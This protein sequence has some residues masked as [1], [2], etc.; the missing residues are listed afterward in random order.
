MVKDLKEFLEEIADALED[1]NTEVKIIIGDEEGLLKKELE[2]GRMA[3]VLRLMESLSDNFVDSFSDIMSA[4]NRAVNAADVV[5]LKTEMTEDINKLFNQI[6]VD[7][8]IQLKI[9]EK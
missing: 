4:V 3:T 8:K 1:E 5:G 2:Q 6:S 7:K 9:V